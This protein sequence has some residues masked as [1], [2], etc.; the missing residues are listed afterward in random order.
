MLFCVASAHLFQEMIV[1]VLDRHVDV[2]EDFFAFGD[3]LDE[4]VVDAGGVEVH[5]ANPAE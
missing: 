3:G 5:Q 1:Y 2:V 4:V